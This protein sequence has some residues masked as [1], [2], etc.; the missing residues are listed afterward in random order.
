MKPVN[1]GSVFCFYQGV[2]ATGLSK[3]FVE[4]RV[5]RALKKQ[6]RVAANFTGNTNFFWIW[7]GGSFFRSC[8][9]Q[10]WLSENQNITFQTQRISNQSLGNEQ[11]SQYLHR[12]FPLYFKAHFLGSMCHRFLPFSSIT[13]QSESASRLQYPEYSL[14]S[15]TI[16]TW[17]R[18]KTKTYLFF[19]FFFSINFP[20]VGFSFKATSSS[21][22]VDTSE[23]IPWARNSSAVMS[24]SFLL[25]LILR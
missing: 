15:T 10:K 7:V 23:S 18:I 11:F 12:T 9:R 24:L 4:M 19:F 14:H 5:F 25:T 6:D 17:K 2:I 16:L 8:N 3:T 21:E 13:N 1:N 22:P 20:F